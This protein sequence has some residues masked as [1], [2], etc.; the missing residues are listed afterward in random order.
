M[1]SEKSIYTYEG[2]TGWKS[3]RPLH[4]FRGMYHDFKRRLPYYL[5]DITDA[6]TYRTVASIIRMYFV[7]YVFIPALVLVPFKG[8]S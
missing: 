8:S 6:F 1:A 7:K 5:S 4:L 2:L 3:L